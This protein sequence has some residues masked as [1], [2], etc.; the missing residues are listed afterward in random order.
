MLWFDDQ[1]D[2]FVAELT[3]Y[4]G[5]YI[6]LFSTAKG[7]H[8]D[9][10]EITRLDEKGNPVSETAVAANGKMDLQIDPNASTE[11]VIPKRS[12]AKDDIPAGENNP[13]NEPEEDAGASPLIIALVVLDALI[14][15]AF[16]V[17]ACCAAVKMRKRRNTG[18]INR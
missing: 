10:L 17:F 4:E 13:L 7:G 11:L 9:D 18:R 3:N 15:A 16:V 8:F 14:I 1:T 2:P 6:S 12:T 5:G